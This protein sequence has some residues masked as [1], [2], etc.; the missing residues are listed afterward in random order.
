MPFRLAGSLF[1]DLFQQLDDVACSKTGQQC[2]KEAAGNTGGLTRCNACK[3]GAVHG[4]HTAHENRLPDPDGPTMDMA[5]KA[6]R[7][8]S[9]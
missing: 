5:M 8:G 2:S 3:V 6:D 4:Q 7:M 1:G 9:M